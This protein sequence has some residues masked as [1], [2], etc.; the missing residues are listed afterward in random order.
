MK[1]TFNWLIS[2]LDAAK[3]GAMQINKRQEKNYKLKYKGQIMKNR[4]EF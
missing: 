4:T 2:R 1:N 3:E